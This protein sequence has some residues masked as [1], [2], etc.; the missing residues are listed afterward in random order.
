MK[1][2]DFLENKIKKER[3]QALFGNDWQQIIINAIMNIKDR[4]IAKPVYYDTKKGNVEAGSYTMGWRIDIVDKPARNKQSLTTELQLTQQQKLEILGG[5]NLSEDKKNCV[6]G[7][8]KIPNS[9]VANYILIEQDFKNA[10]DI[11]NNL[12]DIADYNIPMYLSFRAVN[13]RSKTNA[14][15]GNRSLGVYVKWMQNDYLLI[16]DHPLELG[17]KDVLAQFKKERMLDNK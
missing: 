4:F 1:T 9:G 6:V 11:L 5:I 15:D 12:I 8:T 17:A 14:M 16:F 3:A 13:Y 7:N 10:Q 2:A